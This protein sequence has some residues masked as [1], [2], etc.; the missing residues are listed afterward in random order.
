MRYDDDAGTSMESE[1]GGGA[2]PHA[3]P[4]LHSSEAAFRLLVG[5]V[6]D[7]AIFMLHPDG[8]VAS[9][10]RGAERINGYAAEEVLGRHFS[11]F[12]PP[13][14]AAVGHPA[15]ELEAA[16]R[17]G[18]YEEEGWRVT[19]G[20]GRIW[21]HVVITALRDEAGELV[22]YGKVAHDLTEHRDAELALHESEARFREIAETIQEV[23]WI[24]PPDFSEYLYVS[25]AYEQVWGRP[26]DALHE[27]ANA[28]LEAVHATDRAAVLEYIARLRGGEQARVEYR[29]FRPDGEL[30]WLESH[31]Y[32]VTDA[33]DVIVRIV[34]VTED[35]TERKDREEAQQFLG[36]ASRTLA[37]SLDYEETL[38]RVARL[39]VP[40]VADWCAVDVFEDGCI[41]R[42]AVAHA[43][44]AMQQLARDVGDRFPPDPGAER[45]V[46]R[47]LRTGEA[48][49]VPEVT[50]EVLRAVARSDE[51]HRILLELG[52][53]SA[54]V[55]PMEAHGEVLGAIV[56]IAAESGRRYEQR[57][58]ELAQ[59]LAARAALAVDNAHLFAGMKRRARE[60][61]ALRQATEAVAQSFTVEE[62]IRR[63]A[64]AALVAVGGDAAFV[65]R[66]DAPTG[67]S[68]VV[69]AAGRLAPEPGQKV[70]FERSLA[71]QVIEQRR[72]EVIPSLHGLGRELPARLVEKCGDCAALAVP[73]L[74][75]GEA[76]GALIVLRSP[77]HGGFRDD[78]V[79]R[80][81]T[82]ADLA[83]LAFRKVHLLEESEQRREE[84]E[85]VMASRARLLRGF[86]HDLKNPLGA[87]DGYM[88]LLEDGVLGE[89]ADEQRRS[90]GRARRALKSGLD[91]IDDLVDVARA[92]AGQLEI[93]PEPVDLREVVSEMAEEYRAQA[94]G[95]GLQVHCSAPDRFPLIISDTARIRQVLGN[96]M[97]NAV[98]YTVEGRVTVTTGLRP[99]PDSLRCAVVEVSDTG[100]GIPEDRRHL[101][102]REFAR[103]DPKAAAGAGLG[104]AISRRV[105]KALGGELTYESRDGGGSTFVLWLPQHTVAGEPHGGAQ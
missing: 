50:P 63:I 49:F 13:E 8:R 37:S 39:A 74:D 36:E 30:R 70:A 55:V 80:A 104:L 97:S 87:A 23:F 92:E 43:D 62:V 48:E 11:I 64:D 14:V 69:A 9:W 20:G 52:M 82:F 81:R 35:V 16:A 1:A 60:E 96:L 31:G 56:L 10:N 65:E 54:M 27:D 18:R 40:R 68:V 57:D 66:I 98:K 90:I 28:Y 85:R 22:G 83:A 25:P 32:P 4:E 101:L 15:R 59:D 78:E 53:R 41:R 103:L 75:G 17:A 73:L 46:A 89:M 102:F 6:E 77:S 51:H 72:E 100:P 21:A 71:Q 33:G 88:Q 105:A 29:I 99:G 42:L 34:G 5:S 3:R 2:G 86:S 47:V 19:K 93:R 76:I 58:L 84:L 67:C 94:E 61:A 7:Y 79:A 91:L 44:P 12:Y 26:V 38:A 95:K 45:G 24:A